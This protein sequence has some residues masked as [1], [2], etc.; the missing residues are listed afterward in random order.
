MADE[1]RISV[2]RET[3]RA[4]LAE[5]ELRLIEKLASRE[6]VA[7]LEARLVLLERAAL[8]KGGP[9]DEK[10]NRL[11]QITKSN[12]ELAEFVDARILENS[13]E[14]WTK[15][16]RL[17]ASVLAIIAVVTFLIN[18]FHPFASSGG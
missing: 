16:D 12:A 10:V 1:Q 2:S 8:V 11:V 5:M 18:V 15:R 7:A 14:V 17:V 3:L 9:V 4:E 6:Q 13:G